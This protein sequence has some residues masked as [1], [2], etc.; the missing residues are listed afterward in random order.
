MFKIEIE[1]LRRY[2]AKMKAP[3]YLRYEL[4]PD[5]TKGSEKLIYHGSAFSSLR[6]AQSVAGKLSEYFTDCYFLLDLIYTK[7][8]QLE[9]AVKDVPKYLKVDFNR[10]EKSRCDLL[11][12]SQKTLQAWAHI[13]AIKDFT[14][15]LKYWCFSVS[16]EFSAAANNLFRILLD[17]EAH[18]INTYRSA[19]IL[20]ECNQLK[21]FL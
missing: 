5:I 12:N 21:M 14:N 10:I 2:E 7:L 17:F 6:S 8:K 4:N 11:K 1:D 3:Y 13:N 20:V 19:K 18:F 15:N 9:I 16:K